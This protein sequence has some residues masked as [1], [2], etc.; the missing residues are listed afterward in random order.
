MSIKISKYPSMVNLM[1]VKRRLKPSLHQN[2]NFFLNRYLPIV[3]HF[4]FNVPIII[5]TQI[6][7]T[8]SFFVYPTKMHTTKT[9]PLP[10][11]PQ[12][13]LHSWQL[14]LYECYVCGFYF[15]ANL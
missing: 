10:P 8:Y 7:N 11:A 14:W 15:M 9:L 4:N 5:C 1:T 6:F 3:R 12:V 13:I 2:P